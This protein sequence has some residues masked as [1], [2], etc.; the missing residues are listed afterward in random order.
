MQ[1]CIDDSDIWKMMFEQDLADIE[2]HEFMEK[3]WPGGRPDQD[4]EYQ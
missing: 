3:E 1:L 2:H 4:W